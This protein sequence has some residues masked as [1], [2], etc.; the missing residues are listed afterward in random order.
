[1]ADIIG[2]SGIDHI[3]GPNTET[4]RI[5]GLDGNDSVSGGALADLVDGGNGNDGVHGQ[6]GNDTLYGRAGN[7]TL[8]GGA[9]NDSLEGGTGN[10]YLDG[11]V[12]NDTYTFAVGAGVDHISDYDTTVGNTD[13]VSFTGVASTALTALERQGNDLVLKYGTSDQAIVDNYFHPTSP[14]YKVEQFKFSDGVIWN[15]AA[16]KARV[17]TVGTTGI[18][19]IVGYNDGTNRIYGLDGNDSVSGGALADLVDG[20]NGN[21]GVHGQAG[22]DTLYGRAGNDTLR[23]GAGNDSLEGGTGNDYLD[24]NVGNDTYT[25]AV[26][27]GVDHISDYDTTVGNTDVVS[28][29]GVASTALT[30]LERQ[31]N[32]LVLKYGTSDQAIVDNYFHPT[33]PSYKVEQFK[34]SDGVIW[35]EAAIKAR[36]ITVGTTGINHIVGYNDGTNRIYGLD[37]ND[38][39]SGGA[40]ADLLDGGNGNDAVYG[41]AGNDT[42]YGRA[43][44]DKLRGGA[45]NDSLEG[46]TGNDYLDGGTEIDTASYITATAGVSVNLSLTGA[47]NTGGAGLDTLVSI[48]N[49]IGSNFNDSL[50]GNAGNNVLS[51][52]GG[53]DTLTGGDGNNQ[54]TGGAGRD[55]LNGGPGNDLFKYNL[56]SDSPAGTGRDIIGDFSGAGTTLGDQIS[57]TDIDANTVATGNQAFSW[58]GS[59]A[60]TAAGQLRYAGGVLQGNTD[61]DAA[62]EFEIQLV[63]TPALSVGGAG[64]D[65][66]L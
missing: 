9:G 60:F 55:T 26:G 22:N 4:N 39:V 38:S 10:D 27:A 5:Y 47:Q 37:G 58:I 62:A 2:T 8:R 24:G 29:T 64:T 12:G 56:A 51:G 40:L 18:N 16:I 25:F 19:H 30:A 59:S 48:E 53:N 34:F 36:V 32:D 49:L 41:Q 23:G 54:L 13:V 21:D 57:L 14:S 1:M 63:G 43:G 33:S 28:F 7:D 52:L 44:D 61:A 42:L 65:I 35:N 31:G 50:T 11:N 17:I 20:G 46:G 45:G 15:E 66:L 6:A 3:V